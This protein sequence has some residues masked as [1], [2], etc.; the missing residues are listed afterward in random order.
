MSDPICA[1]CGESVLKCQG[2]C[3]PKKKLLPCPFCGLPSKIVETWIPEAMRENEIPAFNVGCQ[4][5]G[6]RGHAPYGVLENNIAKEID[7]WNRRV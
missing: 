5:V 2:F 1:N 7:R 6:C 4:N 3:E